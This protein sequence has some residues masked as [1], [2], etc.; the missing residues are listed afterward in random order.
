MSIINNKNN[1]FF[2]VKNNVKDDKT[3]NT[4]HAVSNTGHAKKPELFSNADQKSTV[5][6]TSKNFAVNN[7]S[8]K[9]HTP[10]QFNEFISGLTELANKNLSPAKMEEKCVA[11]ATGYS[12]DPKEIAQIKAQLFKLFNNLGHH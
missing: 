11:I 2:N 4:S 7:I 12:S 5:G 1:K 3:M 6:G 8:R 10:A 9:E